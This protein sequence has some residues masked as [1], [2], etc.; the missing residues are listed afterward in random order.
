MKSIDLSSPD[1]LRMLCDLRAELEV[2]SVRQICRKSD[3]K[4]K[5]AAQLLP[6]LNRL[7]KATQDQNY[8]DFMQEDQVLHRTIIELSDAP[9][10]KAIWQ[11]V[12]ETVAQFHRE[13]FDQYWPD[14]R[15]LMRE[16]EYLVNTICSMDL[17]AAEDGIRNHLQAIWFRI[18]NRGD[19]Q[20]P[21]TS[22]LARAD[23]YVA[24][25]LQHSL[26]LKQVAA[27]VAF[28][29]AGHLS[30]LFKARYGKS[31]Q[32]YVQEMRLDK[33]ASLL[34]HT[35]LPVSTIASRVG[36]QDVSRFGQHFKRQFGITPNKW[37]QH[38]KATPV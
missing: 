15:V 11:T 36:Y 9:A 33:A 24:F 26:T 13:S 32:L 5:V 7:K 3:G 1:N 29:S 14:L 19:E 12:W 37:R 30:K 21:Q 35:V 8:A 20:Q 23:S 4:E 27:E 18:A 31:F 34:Q 38:K 22:P 17:S 25:N 28:T 10:L 16:H 2:F 6:I